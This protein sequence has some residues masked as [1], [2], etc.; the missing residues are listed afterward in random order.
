M[1]KSK[2]AFTLLELFI[3]IALLGTL[4]TVLFV[5][6]K[7]FLARNQFENSVNGFHSRLQQF[8]IVAMSYESDIE[9]IIYKD[10]EELFYK[11]QVNEPLAIPDAGKAFVLK[12]VAEVSVGD[13]KR[14]RI[15]SRSSHRVE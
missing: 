11:F 1:R 4:S 6:I 10:K 5:Q 12:G 8:K 3:C 7:D 15:C 9:L 13:K 2:K 14:R